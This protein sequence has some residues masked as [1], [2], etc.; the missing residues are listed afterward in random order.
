MLR[1]PNTASMALMSREPPVVV[2]VKPMARLALLLPYPGVVSRGQRAT[3]VHL[4][5]PLASIRAYPRCM[6]SDYYNVFCHESIAHLISVTAHRSMSDSNSRAIAVASTI[7]VQ[8][9][10]G[11]KCECK[12]SCAC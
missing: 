12:S 1:R 2:P 6:C 9:Q 4:L 5:P 8:S 7:N 3:C 11:A 10:C